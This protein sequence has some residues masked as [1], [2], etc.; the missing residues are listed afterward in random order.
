MTISN[1]AKKVLSNF[2]FSAI[3]SV[4]LNFI[5]P[6]PDLTG[7][8]T[9][10]ILTTFFFVL[11][12]FYG[13]EDFNITGQWPR[14]AKVIKNVIGNI[15]AGILLTAGFILCGMLLYILALHW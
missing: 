12:T 9:I 4:I 2:T 7:W 8:W 3:A 5:I 10:S 6:A 14:R 13:D 15:L 11:G 1:N